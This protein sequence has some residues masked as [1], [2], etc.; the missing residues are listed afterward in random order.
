MRKRCAAG[1][2]KSKKPKVIRAFSLHITSQIYFYYS[3]ILPIFNYNKQT[4]NM[5]I[6]RFNDG[7]EFDTSG[8]MRT[9]KRYDGWYVVGGGMLIPV[10]SEEEGKEIVETK[11][12]KV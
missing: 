12:E 3:I 9:E 11:K 6:L 4:K 7:E 10:D 2:E 1:R 8:E 5:S